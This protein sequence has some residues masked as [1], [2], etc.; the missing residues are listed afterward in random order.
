MGPE[1]DA[2][3]GPNAF[4]YNIN[5]EKTGVEVDTALGGLG[6]HGVVITIEKRLASAPVNSPAAATIVLGGGFGQGGIGP[7]LNIG[8]G[9]GDDDVVIVTGFDY[10]EQ[11]LAGPM[12][13][14]GG[15]ASV[16]IGITS[17]SKNAAFLM[18]YGNG[19]LPPLAIPLPEDDSGD[20]EIGAGLSINLGLGRVGGISPVTDPQPFSMVTQPL[21]RTFTA[22]VG[23]EGSVHFD[24]GLA[25]L[26]PCGRF[27]LRELVAEFRAV[28]ESPQSTISVIAFAD[29]SDTEQFNDQLTQNRAATVREALIRMMGRQPNDPA[30]PAPLAGIR[31]FGL[32]ELPARGLVSPAEAQMNAQERA[33]VARKKALFA[34]PLADGVKDQRWRTVTVLLNNLITADLRVSLDESAP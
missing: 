19:S 28:F 2:V 30:L 9:T 18:L 23:T 34:P 20:N 33:L 10:S 4:R 1:I 11:S 8:G 5:V 17:R 22:P 13:F 12:M 7:G 15:T 27:A 21:T 3:T 25:V 31:T 24:L 29:P 14:L 32:G 6:L 16:G 26:R